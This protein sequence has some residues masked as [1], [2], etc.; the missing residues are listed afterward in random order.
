MTTFKVELQHRLTG[1]RKVVDI[2]AM[3]GLDAQRYAEKRYTAHRACTAQSL[4]YYERL[5][6]G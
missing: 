5:Q 4:Q 2:K 1:S 6:R 3:F